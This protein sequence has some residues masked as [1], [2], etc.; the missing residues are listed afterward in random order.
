M[1]IQAIL[2]ETYSITLGSND[3]PR[4][5]FMKGESI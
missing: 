3:G 2:I 4:V 5:I 1:F